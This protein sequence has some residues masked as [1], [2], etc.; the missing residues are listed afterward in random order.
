MTVK[1]ESITAIE[2]TFGSGDGSNPITVNKGS[3]NGS[4]WTGEADEVVFSVGGS[5]GHRR[6]AGVTVTLNGE[7]TMV[8]YTDYMTSCGAG[9]GIDNT[10]TDAPAAIKVLRDGQLII[11]VDNKEYNILGF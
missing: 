10:A 5:S 6:I 2:I 11:V 7:S 4:K 3:L 1:A 9:T 8:I